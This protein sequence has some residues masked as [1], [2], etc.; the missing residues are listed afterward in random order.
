MDAIVIYLEVVVSGKTSG[1]YQEN[2]RNDT[3]LTILRK[4][5]M[6]AMRSR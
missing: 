2:R 1:T 4:M 5:Q 3:Q 6:L